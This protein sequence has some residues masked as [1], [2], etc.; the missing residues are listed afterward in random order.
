VSQT[1]Q[2]SGESATLLAKQAAA[3]GLSV[4]AWI[5]ELAHEKAMVEEAPREQQEAGAAIAR[6]LEIQKRVKPDP[7]GWTVRD[8]INHGRR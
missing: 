7:E 8:Y 5:E 6:I 3:H 2:I 4:E 1:I